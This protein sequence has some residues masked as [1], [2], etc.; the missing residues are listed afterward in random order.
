VEEQDV[1]VDNC[2]VGAV[3]AADFGAFVAD[4]DSEYH[5]I[6]HRY[7]DEEASSHPES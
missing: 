6:D 2:D 1:R 3:V 7:Y 4:I 5:C